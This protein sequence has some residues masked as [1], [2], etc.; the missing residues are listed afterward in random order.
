MTNFDKL[1][2]FEILLEHAAS[3]EHAGEAVLDRIWG[4]IFFVPSGGD[5]SRDSREF[6]PVLYPRG[7]ATMMAVFTTLERVDDAIS[8]LAPF[9][10]T[11]TGANLI[12]GLQPT[13]GLVINPGSTIGMELLPEA[14]QMIKGRQSQKPQ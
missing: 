14:V 3:D 8:K 1:E 5:I 10:F 2:P 11:L 13:V 7:A 9:V 12:S 4:E 6:R